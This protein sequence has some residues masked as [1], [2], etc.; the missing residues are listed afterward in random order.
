MTVTRSWRREACDGK[1]VTKGRRSPSFFGIS[2]TSVRS[3]D[4]VG[5]R[6]G[7][8]RRFGMPAAGFDRLVKGESE[9]KIDEARRS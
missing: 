3:T 7:L 2:P 8:S 1:L 4:V 6:S 5:D 9:Q